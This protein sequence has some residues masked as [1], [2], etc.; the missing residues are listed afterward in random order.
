MF[1]YEKLSFYWIECVKS[2]KNKIFLSFLYLLSRIYKM[3]VLRRRERILALPKKKFD[4]KVIGVGNIVLGGTG[5]TPLVIWLAKKNLEKGLRVGVVFR[6]YAGEARGTLIVQDGKNI[7]STP[8]IAGDEAYLV[9]K[10]VPNAI[11]IVDRVKERAIEFLQNEHGCDIVILDDAFQYWSIQKD[12]DIVTIDAIDPWGGGYMFPRGFLREPKESLSRANIVVI[13]RFD[14]IDYKDLLK[15]IQDIKSINFNAKILLM[16]YVPKKLVDMSLYKEYNF[17]VLNNKRVF[18][19]C[20]IGN[21]DSFFLTC[22]NLGINIVGSTSFPDH[23]RY[24]EKDLLRLYNK[25]KT[26]NVDVF[27]TT[28]KDIVK[29]NFLKGSNL[30]LY[31]LLIEAEIFSEGGK[32]V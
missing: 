23:I 4:L 24:T 5:K 26:L 13:S 29:L 10:K 22:K 25:S 2:G 3:F 21:P 9:S 32:N 31:A 14:L 20:G 15:L 30:L 19:F 7:L 18:A 12:L 8:Y 27:L 11:V 16:R 17:N 1:L 6:G 28:E